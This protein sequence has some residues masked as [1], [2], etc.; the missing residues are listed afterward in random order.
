MSQTSYAANSAAAFAGIEGDGKPSYKVHKINQE[1]SAIPYGIALAR[2]SSENKAK[3]TSAATDEIVGVAVNTFW[4]DNQALSGSNGVDAGD[5]LSVMAFGTVW[6][7]VEEAVSAGDIPFVRIANGVG[8]PT[9]TQKG[10][11]RKSTDSGTA[12][13]L[14][15]AIYQIGASA[16]GFALL[17]LF[18][19]MD[20]HEEV[21]QIS[22]D[23]GEATEDVT[24]KIFKTPADRFFVVTGVDYVNPTGLS[25]DATNFFGIKLVHGSGPTVAATWSTE[26]GEEG[27][28][29]ANTMVA[30]TLG[31]AA[32]RIVPPATEVS[33]LLDEDGS[34]TLPAGR[35]CVKGYYI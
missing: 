3:L 35:A 1:S 25:N 9:K 28:L 20:L 4:A 6:V 13:R 8:D 14:P 17:E 33:L 7:E 31:V 21:E 12:R 27:A 23:H 29:G 2:G 11:F 10:A 18:G 5:Q 19:G 34:Q 16:G 15:N 26:T 22:V 32:N 24:V 30:L